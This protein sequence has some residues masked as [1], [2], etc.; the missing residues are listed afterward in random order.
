[1]TTAEFINKWK[2]GKLGRKKQHSGYR[3][4]D[5]DHCSLLVRATR[6]RH[7]PT[8]SELLGINFGHGICLFTSNVRTL[9]RVVFKDLTKP[10]PVVTN[11]ILKEDDEKILESGII[12]MTDDYVLLEVG[13]TPWLIG[14]DP[15]FKEFDSFK[16]NMAVSVPRRVQSVALA[17]PLCKPEK[18]QITGID[19]LLKRMPSD[20]EPQFL[21]SKDIEIL[22][23]PPKPGD[24]GFSLTDCK[25]RSVYTDGDTVAIPL[26]LDSYAAK[27]FQGKEYLK[28]VQRYNVATT[29]LK[30]YVPSKWED[31][32]VDDGEGKIVI[33]FRN[34]Q[35]YV[36]G[37]VTEKWGPRSFT[38]NGWY[39]VLGKSPFV[40]MKASR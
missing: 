18:D 23:N 7:R 9:R 26:Q 20:F 27:S 40:G 37:T 6:R 5:G 2:A 19:L 35:T 15:D 4:L 13:E 21:S 14:H 10:M 29:R 33:D 38:V 30:K 8:G 3:V 22:M 34:N 31:I 11:T 12:D 17:I 24:F 16:Y 1:M 36:K 32:E 28:K 39:Q 25:V